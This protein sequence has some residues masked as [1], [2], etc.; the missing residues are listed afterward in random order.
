MLYN[1]IIHIIIV[2]DIFQKYPYHL[3]LTIGH[4]KKNNIKIKYIS[5]INKLKF[6]YYNILLINFT[7]N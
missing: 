4:L 6:Y 7:N 5:M 1:L 2:I 3:N